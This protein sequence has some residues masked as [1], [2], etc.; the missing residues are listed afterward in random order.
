MYFSKDMLNLTTLQIRICSSLT[1]L[2]NI[3]HASCLKKIIVNHYQIL[4]DV[5][6][7][8]SLNG[9]VR[10]LIVYFLE[11]ESIK[12]IEQLKRLKGIFIVNCP[13]P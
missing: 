13:R 9:L 5:P 3:V 12:V 10:I 7:I 4:K 8:K 11:L 6:T 2:P 1:E